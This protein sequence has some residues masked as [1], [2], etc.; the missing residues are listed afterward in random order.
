MKNHASTRTAAAALLCLA[1]ALTVNA[2]PRPRPQPIESPVVHP[3]RTVTFAFRAPNAKQVELNA[4]FL[5]S[6]QPLT[7]DAS[8]VWRV[9]VGPVEPNLYP[10][11][12]VVDGVTVADPGNADLFPNERF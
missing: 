9:T 12:F 1:F 10:Y 8:G 2:Q 5:K 3:D 7:M 4:Q 11:S 6:N